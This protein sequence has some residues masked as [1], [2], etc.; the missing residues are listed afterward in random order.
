M[1]YQKKTGN[2]I[3]IGVVNKY[4]VDVIENG[5]PY[6]LHDRNFN[7]KLREILEIAGITQKVKAY[8]CCLKTKRKVLGINKKCEIMAS[9]DLRRSFA[10]NFYGK[11][12]TTIIMRMTGH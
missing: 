7:R 11:V 10:T 12:E 3:T 8:K 4:A 6:K 9:Q 5:L 2:K 1:T